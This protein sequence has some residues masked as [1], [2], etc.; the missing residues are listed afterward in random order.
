MYINLLPYPQES[1]ASQ[2]TNMSKHMSWVVPGE[3][4]PEPP[5]NP[6]P[7]KCEQ[8]LKDTKLNRVAKAIGYTF[9]NPEILWEALQVEGFGATIESTPDRPIT[10][11]G[12]QLLSTLG[13]GYATWLVTEEWYYYRDLSEGCTLQ[14]SPHVLPDSGRI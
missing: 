13:H 11:K 12:N 3:R 8:T 6:P 14:Y 4:E 10:Y 7:Q 2:S 1:R 5:P 9:K